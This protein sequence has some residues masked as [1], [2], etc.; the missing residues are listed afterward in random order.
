MLKSSSAELNGTELTWLDQPPANLSQAKVLVIVDDANFS[1]SQQIPISE[2]YEFADLAGKL[3][4][5]GDEVKAQRTQRD[6]W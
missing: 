3:Q 4:W 2:R 5:R 6:A 1:A